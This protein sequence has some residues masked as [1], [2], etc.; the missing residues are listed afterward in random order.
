MIA[1]IQILQGT[2]NKESTADD[3]ILK[4]RDSRSCMYHCDS[5]KSGVV[6]RTAP[7]LERIHVVTAASPQRDNSI[8]FKPQGL[9]HRL[10][11]HQKLQH[12]PELDGYEDFR[13]ELSSSHN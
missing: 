4:L 12:N 1:G 6:S 13:H 9:H 5:S 2:L 11:A 7:R 10:A 3:V 8:D